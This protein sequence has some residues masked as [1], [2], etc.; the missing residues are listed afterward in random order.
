MPTQPSPQLRATNDNYYRQIMKLRFRVNQGEALRQ[1]VDAPTSVVTI[2]VNPKQLT[3]EERNLLADRMN[4]IDVR[5]LGCTMHGKEV[6]VSTDHIT[7]NLATFEA[8]M[9]AVRAN[10]QK[11]RPTAQAQQKADGSTRKGS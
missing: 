2:Q 7:S 1:G 11:V 9:A 5:Q 8:L 4:G 6:Y 10:E 3:Q